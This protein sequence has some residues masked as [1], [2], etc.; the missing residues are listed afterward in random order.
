MWGAHLDINMHVTLL[1]VVEVDVWMPP[2][3][4]H[5]RGVLL[6]AHG[7]FHPVI[8]QLCQAITPL[9]MALVKK[10]PQLAQERMMTFSIQWLI[11]RSSTALSP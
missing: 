5:L 6:D 11:A 7:A 4:S 1:M 8:N 9:V 3:W 10:A 2:V